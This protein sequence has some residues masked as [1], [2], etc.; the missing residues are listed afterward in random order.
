MAMHNIVRSRSPTAPTNE[1]QTVIDGVTERQTKSRQATLISRRFSG[2][3]SRRMA[4]SSADVRSDGFA[5]VGE[6]LA[7]AP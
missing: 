5:L 1:L 2:P 4:F 7:T 3:C 6:R